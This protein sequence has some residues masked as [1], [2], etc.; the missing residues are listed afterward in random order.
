[1]MMRL[2][3]AV[4]AQPAVAP[5]S[6][7]RG[8]VAG[9]NE[10]AVAPF[11]DDPAVA[12]EIKPRY[13]AVSAPVVSDRVRPGKPAWSAEDE[14]LG[15]HDAAPLLIGGQGVLTSRNRVSSRSTP[16]RASECG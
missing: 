6:H 12:W 16:L 9:P 3:A 4:V 7:V 13:R 11:R 8:S 2:A 15:N 1:M 5:A 10:H 14:D